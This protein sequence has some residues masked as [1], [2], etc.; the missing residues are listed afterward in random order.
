MIT[1][2]LY[3]KLGKKF[4][5]EWTLDAKSPAEALHAI[6]VLKGGLFDFIWDMEQHVQG[7]HVMVNE[8][9][10]GEAQLAMYA[11][12]TEVKIVPLLRGA[13]TKGILQIVAGVALIAIGIVVSY[14]NAPIGWA[15]INLGAA[16]AF[17]GVA[18]LLMNSPTSPLGAAQDKSRSSYIFSGPVNTVQQG[19]CVP[20]CYGAPITGS[21]VIA[22]GI[23]TVDIHVT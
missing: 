2:R 23:E 6:N 21:A 16:V 3:G 4:G 8:K 22:A 15:I 14:Y 11:I 10:I 13:D 1:V 5:R 9:T 20:V 12:D 18:R 19:E 7:Y 17:G